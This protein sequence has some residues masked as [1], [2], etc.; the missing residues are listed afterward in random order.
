VSD[1]PWK[2]RIVGYSDEP[3]DQLLANPKNWRTH[4]GSQADALRGVLA[5]V[6]IVQNVIANRRSGHLVDGHLRVMEALKSSQPTIPVTW[7]DLSDEEEALILAML[8][9]LSALAGTDATQLD[10]LLRDVS[11]DN[12]ALQTMLDD[13]ATDAGI[14]PESSSG[15]SSPPSEESSDNTTVACPACGHHFTIIFAKPEPKRRKRTR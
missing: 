5:D 6:G 4:P 7:V 8:D 1:Q 9:P 10:A 14:V 2:N 12:A 3:P 11:T 15:E 13:L